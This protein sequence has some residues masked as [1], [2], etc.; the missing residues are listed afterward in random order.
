M[1]L[2]PNKLRSIVL[3]LLL[4]SAPVTFAQSGKC[5]L[6][7]KEI[8]QFRGYSIGQTFTD[9]AKLAQNGGSEISTGYAQFV[10]EQDPKKATEENSPRRMSWGFFNEKISNITIMYLAYQPKD[11][12]TFVNDFSGSYKLPSAI[13]KR[14]SDG[15]AMAECNGFVILLQADRIPSTGFVLPR[16]RIVDL[17]SG[18]NKKNFYQML[19]YEKKLNE[20]ERSRQKP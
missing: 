13:F 17:K 15:E 20:L 19:E 11:I 7:R 4:A 18:Y 6:T 12:D 14:K 16:A 1:I 2:H 9:V 3:S 8:P 5:E 10:G